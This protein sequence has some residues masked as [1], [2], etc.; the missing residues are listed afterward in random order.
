MFVNT[1]SYAPVVKWISQRSSKPLFQVRILAGA[2]WKP[3]NKA[4][5]VLKETTLI[6]KDGYTIK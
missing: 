6:S 2:Q 5:M 4:Q 1:C 3:I